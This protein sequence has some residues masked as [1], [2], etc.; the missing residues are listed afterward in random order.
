[1]GVWFWGVGGSLYLDK[2]LEVSSS[3]KGFV[4]AH[5]NKK[6]QL[7]LG[8]V[9]KSLSWRKTAR[10]GLEESPVVAKSAERKTEEAGGENKQKKS[11]R[12]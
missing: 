6:K 7:R 10:G 4:N 12:G 8:P 5:F 2:G 3:A 9:T 1:M 11:T